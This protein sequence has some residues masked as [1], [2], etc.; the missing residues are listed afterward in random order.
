MTYPREKNIVLHMKLVDKCEEMVDIC[1]E[2]KLS[3][4]ILFR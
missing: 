1:E 2:V 3:K 4:Q